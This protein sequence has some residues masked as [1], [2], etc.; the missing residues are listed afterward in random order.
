VKT[1]ELGGGRGDDGGKT[2]PGRKR[3]V[4]VD[5]LGLLL[6][7]CVSRATMDDAVAA[8]QAL[9]HLGHAT[10]PRVAVIGADRTYHHHRLTRWIETASPGNWHVAVVR[11]PEGSRGFGLLL[12]RWGVER[13]L[14]WPLS[15]SP[16][17]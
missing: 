3:Q 17:G 6:V 12:K 7:V 10:S 16:Q 14:A 11:R 13:T 5:T 2:I 8:P 1:P 4:R 9:Q 15:S